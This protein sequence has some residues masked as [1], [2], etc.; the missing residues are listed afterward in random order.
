[1]EISKLKQGHATGV[2]KSRR[3]LVQ[4]G[5]G[6]WLMPA[7]LVSAQATDSAG[8]GTKGA[9]TLPK[10]GN[11]FCAAFQ[12]EHGEHWVGLFTLPTPNGESERAMGGVV[13]SSATRQGDLL[14]AHKLPSRPHGLTV[15]PEGDRVVIAPRRPGDWL[16]SWW[17]C[18]NQMDIYWNDAASSLNGHLA[19]GQLDGDTIA[20]TTETDKLTGEGR[21]VRRDGKSLAVLDSHASGGPDGHEM[22]FLREG[23]PGHPSGKYRLPCLLVANGGQRVNPLKGREAERELPLESNL[24][25]LDARTGEPIDHWVVED[26]WLSLRHMALSPTGTVAIAMQAKH[27]NMAD[28]QTA[29]VVSILRQ[30]RLRVPEIKSQPAFAGYAGSVVALA[31][32]FV[33]TA[34]KAN[35]L[36]W[37]GDDGTVLKQAPWANACAAAYLQNSVWI[38][39]DGPNQFDNHAV[40]YPLSRSEP[41]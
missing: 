29:P 11:F 28:R 14:V 33:M 27:T 22:L 23:L 20:W 31:N 18:D 21:L 4:A 26:K 10:D 32:G 34:P 8:L 3:A 13:I 2:N 15:A 19:F 16:A 1:M 39:K 12:D 37:L 30:G 41:V 5:L 6:A 40:I 36:A 9:L 38:A 25:L 17:P 7:G 35:T 24:T